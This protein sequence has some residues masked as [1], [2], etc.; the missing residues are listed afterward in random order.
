MLPFIKCYFCIP[1][2]D[3]CKN[4]DDVKNQM[5]LIPFMRKR[6]MHCTYQYF[7]SFFCL[8][9]WCSK[10]LSFIISFLSVRKISFSHSFR[11]GLLAMN[12]SRFPLS[13][14]VFISPSFLNGSFVRYRI[15]GWKFSFP[16]ALSRY[17]ATSCW[18]PSFR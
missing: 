11:R 13:E 5:W 4:S 18:H 8:P 12:S 6:T 3:W 14:N 10:I 17:C 1:Q 2:N 7:C 15:C 9:S 16:L